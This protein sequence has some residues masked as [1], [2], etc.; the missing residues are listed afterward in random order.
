[1]QNSPV[2]HSLKGLADT[3]NSV[4]MNPATALGLEE[5]TEGRVALKNPERQKG[6]ASLPAH[7]QW[8]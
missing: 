4:L 1:M 7:S 6:E 8:P 3:T 2:S 5:K